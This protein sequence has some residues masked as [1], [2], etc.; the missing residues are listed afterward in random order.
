MR[1]E[2]GLDRVPIPGGFYSNAQAVP[3]SKTPVP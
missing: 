2:T 1:R 3:T